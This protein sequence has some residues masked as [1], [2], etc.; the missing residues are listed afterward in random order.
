VPSLQPIRLRSHVVALRIRRARRALRTRRATH[1]LGALLL[2]VVSVAVT[3][4]LPVTATER[5]SG[6]V[7]G[8]V[9]QDFN[10]NGVRDTALRLGRAQDG[11]IAGVVVRAFDRSGVLVGET[12]SGAT[13]AY[14]LAVTDAETRD[15]RIEFSVPDTP[16]L[17]GLQPAP[18][19]VTTGASGST[20]GTTV[21]FATL[22]DTGVNLGLFRPGEFC[23][24]DPTL[25]TCAYHRGTGTSTTVGAFTL[26]GAMNGFTDQNAVSTRIG[27]SLELGSVFGIGVDRTRNAYFGTHLKRHVEYGI[28]GPTNTIYRINLD[29][30]DEVSIFVTLPGEL[31]LHDPTPAGTFPAYS[32]DVGVFPFVGRVGLGDVDVTPDGRMLLA[33]DIDETDP[34][35]YFVPIVG[36]GDAVTAGEYAV[37]GIPRPDVDGVERPA[38]FDAIGCPGIWHPM[39]IGVRG[40]RILVGGVC[41]AEDTVTP[42]LPNGP[43]LTQS[44][45]FVLE[46]S[47]ARD[48]SGSFEVIWAA[49]LGYERGCVYREGTRIAC[50]D[51]TSRVGTIATADWGAWNEY[52]ILRAIDGPTG[53][54]FASN[55]QAMLANIEILDTGGLVLGF[56]DRYQDQVMVGNAAW[57]QGYVDNYPT[58]P[59][60][61]PRGAGS[62]AGGDIL[63]VCAAADG[64]LS[65]EVGGTCAAPD[66]PGGAHL[67][68]SGQREYFQD[69]YVSWGTPP[70]HPETMT[71]GL[72]S[73]PGFPGVW[74]NAYDV[75]RLGSQGTYALGPAAARLGAAFRGSAS[76]YGAQIGGRD[77]GNLNGFSKGIGLADLEVVCGYAPIEIGDRLWWDQDGD[78]V[79]DAGE[80]GIA[81]VTVRLYD[82]DGTLVAT[83]VTDA[84]GQYRFTSADGVEPG[85]GYEIRFDEP[86]DYAEGGPLEDFLLTSAEATGPPGSSAEPSEVDSDASL[87]GTGTFGVSAFP[88]IAVAALEPGDSVQ[89]YDAGFVRPVAMGDVVWID[90][91]G[92]GIQDAGEPGLA[93][94]VVTLFTPVR[95]A[96]G[97]IVGYEPVTNLLGEPATA[98]TDVFGRYLIDDLLPGEYVAQFTLPPDYRFTTPSAEGS[99]SGDDSDAVP[100]TDPLVGLTAPFLISGFPDGDTVAVGDYAFGDGLR[101]GHVNPTIDA[102]VI[103]LGTIAG[104][105]WRDSDRDGLLEPGEPAL[106]GREVRLLDA[107]GAVIATTTTAA[108]GSYAF[109]DLPPGTYTVET[110]TPVGLAPTIEGAGSPQNDS[111]TS[112]VSVTLAYGSMQQTDVDLG[113][114]D[115]AITG[116]VWLDADESA[117]IDAG[118]QPIGRIEVQLRD[119]DGA[120]IATTTTAADGTYRFDELAQGDYTVVFVA[121]AGS[122]ATTPLSVPVTLDASVAVVDAGLVPPSVT[123]GG[124]V[125]YDTDEDGE[126][127]PFQPEIPDELDGDGEPIP[128]TGSSEVPA[129]PFLPGVTVAITTVDG[130]PVYDVYGQLVGPVMTDE[131]GRYVFADLPP[132]TYRVTS[133]VPAG[134]EATTDALRGLGDADGGR[135][136]GP[137]ARLR[138]LRATPGD[139]RCGVGGHRR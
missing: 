128:G 106:E 86:A 62:M 48:G 11:G 133:T 49:S 20:R 44:T 53:G 105:L 69:A 99:T 39:G 137:H 126:R 139:H 104:T 7:T 117:T 47:G 71:G 84:N 107:D 85:V 65:T 56:R 103:P 113:F 90:L 129:E 77:Y 50:S 91:D 102:G 37:T 118:E 100:T 93:G 28:G 46:Y 38:A 16:A 74:A 81:G 138:V 72:A 1:L 121:P 24:D 127:D 109:T 58:P 101:A 115:L 135:L 13:G 87:V 68:A 54:L 66:L 3:G 94:V 45:A 83:T 26:P 76:G 116:T 8:S 96:D 61:Y 10:A 52:P 67:D 5:F 15:V 19:T 21:Q 34:K 89:T 79:Q 40:E 120:L 12:T 14:A 125:F 2:L 112:P 35:L 42:A 23:E 6:T 119:A 27:S 110:D 134:M 60:A 123:V 82:A 124:S 18:S 57:S 41:G 73:Q 132:G 63:R 29:R 98:T 59:L 80:P 130:E 4:S 31:P 111:S 88:S 70:N 75:T 95:D 22:G 108:D 25:I 55:P 43:H 30:P 114:V 17:R 51:A 64:R 33:V 78:G 136:G 92:D 36:S 9:F 131:D 32:G 122:T 97:A